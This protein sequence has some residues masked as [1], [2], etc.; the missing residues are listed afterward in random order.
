[1]P[2]KPC[3]TNDVECEIVEP[4]AW[5]I[6][7]EELDAKDRTSDVDDVTT[8]VDMV[9]GTTP[10]LPPIRKALRRGIA[11][12]ILRGRITRDTVA[13]MATKGKSVKAIAEHTGLNPA[14]VSRHLKVSLEEYASLESRN[15]SEME[16]MRV[17][18]R[19]I[20]EGVADTAFKLVEENAA[21][22]AV[23]LKAVEQVMQMHGLH[24]AG[25]E[26]DNKQTVK[27]IAERVRAIS[28]LIGKSLDGAMPKTAEVTRKSNGLMKQLLEEDRVK[29]KG[30]A[31]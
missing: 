24:E 16:R 28:P 3:D 13:K 22:G 26:N 5:E 1:M 11:K 4:C 19:S 30:A 20:T 31:E 12:Q 15:P 2:A 23:A 7:G 18:A 14:T 17:W 9:I 29:R 10:A 25:E 8:Q 6:F 27:S 21:Y